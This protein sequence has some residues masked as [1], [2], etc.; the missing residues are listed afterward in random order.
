MAHEKAEVLLEQILRRL[1]ADREAYFY[2]THA[3]AELDL[4]IVRAGRRW[5]SR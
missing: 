3:G 1:A 5:A 2:A 4:L